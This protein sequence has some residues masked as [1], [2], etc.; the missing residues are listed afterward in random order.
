MS[1]INIISMIGG[2]ALFLYGMQVMGD[3]LKAGSSGAMKNALAE[4]TNNPVKSFLLGLLVTSVIQSSTATIVLTSGLVGAGMMTLHQS[5]GIIVG[6]NVGTT[7]TG[8]IIRLLDVET[9]EGAT[10]LLSLFKPDTLAPLAAVIGL[11]L[12][13]IPNNKNYET[14]GN[15]SM[16]FGVLFTGLLAM[17][18]A[19]SP[20]SS[21]PVFQGWMIKFSANPVLGF[22]VGFAVAF[23]L[24][25]S[26]ATVGIL[27]AISMT[28]TLVYSAVYPMILGIYLGDAVTTAIVCSIGAKA[29]AKRTGVIHVCLNISQE[30]LIFVAMFILYETGMLDGVWNSVMTPGSIANL[31][32]AFKLICAVIL[33]PLSNTYERLSLK[34]V[35]DDVQ[36]GESIDKELEMLNEKLFTSPALALESARTATARMLELAGSNTLNAM[37][38]LKHYDAKEIERINENEVHIDNLSDA[39]SNY[40]VK[41]SPYITSPGDNDLLNFYLQCSSEFERIGDYAV[42][43]TESAQELVD[44]KRSFTD[45]AQAELDV[46]KAGLN[47]ILDLSY[48]TFTERDFVRAR[49]IEPLEEVMDDITAILK[50]NHTQRLR[51]GLCSTTAGLIFL[52]CLVNIEAISDKCSNIGVFTLALVDDKVMMS[53]HEY[54]KMLHRGNDLEYNNTYTEVHDRY[55][56]M[57]EAAYAPYN[58][59][60]IINTEG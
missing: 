50:N 31:H 51:K 43:L 45:I 11:I 46:A 48:Y 57:L 10:S 54:L 53:H 52:D 7:M 8:Q 30:I 4:V 9:A 32:T 25:S 59:D 36:L 16:G 56:K 14:A 2:L 28:G 27:Q 35:P 49:Q 38:V 21:S 55:H 33:L 41:L 17:T 37:E 39:V 24:Q 5:V 12:L 15:V 58:K 42:H 23:V 1:I 44:K 20:L 6:A 34:I 47:E 18:A 19:V 60:S 29:D 40:L 13:K 22:L 26:S 3:G